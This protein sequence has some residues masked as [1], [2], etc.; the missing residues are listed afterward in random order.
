MR[1]NITRGGNYLQQR[2][3]RMYNN[4]FKNKFNQVTNDININGN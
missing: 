2:V 4:M 1:F 3:K